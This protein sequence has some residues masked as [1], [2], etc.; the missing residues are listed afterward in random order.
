MSSAISSNKQEFPNPQ[1]AFFFKL[2]LGIKSKKKFFFIFG[3]SI[4]DYF[5]L[6][7]WDSSARDQIP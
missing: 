3:T 2:M 6:D 7:L 5:P 4:V 1:C